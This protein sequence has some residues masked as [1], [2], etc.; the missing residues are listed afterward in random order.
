MK[1]LTTL[2]LLFF[3]LSMYT[4]DSEFISLF[5]GQSLEGWTSSTENPESFSVKDGAIICKGGRAHL[6]YT[7]S[8]GNAD[9]KNFEL[10]L[11]AMTTEKSN[12]GVYFHTVY[13]EEGWPNVGFEAQVNSSHL[14]PRKTGSLYGVVNMWVPLP[15]QQKFK[16]KVGQNNEV[17]V[18]QSSA[19]SKDNEWF[20]YHIT[21]KDQQIILRVN[22]D[23][24][25]DW[26]QPEGWIRER[27]IGRGTIGFQAHDPKSEVHYKDIMIKVL[28]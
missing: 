4:Q 26:T 13:Q 25:V 6:F 21:V 23:I 18:P 7:G 27:R 19:P 16:S 2:L 3:A 20:D 8:V 14:D 15:G 22:D 11:K 9:F 28:D 1:A 17:F 5:D 12:S 24:T 10:K